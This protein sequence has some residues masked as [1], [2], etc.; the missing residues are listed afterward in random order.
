MR[1]S[2]FILLICYIVV[3]VSVNFIKLFFFFKQ[4]T[5]YEVRISDWSSDVCSSD[6][7]EAKSC[8]GLSAANSQWRNA[9]SSSAW[10]NAT[11]VSGVGRKV[12][13]PLLVNRTRARRSRPRRAT[14]FR[15]AIV[16]VRDAVSSSVRI[17]VTN[18]S[19]E[20]IGRAHV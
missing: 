16:A 1:L 13:R 19:L 9:L 5:A 10:T 3:D 11:W 2:N 6:L 12:S 17:V 7:I 8:S 20:A 4:K 14:S 18:H 15:R